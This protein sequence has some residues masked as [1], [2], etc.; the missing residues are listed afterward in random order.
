MSVEWNVYVNGTYVGTVMASR[1]EDA[2]CA[3]WSEFHPS[4]DA[5]VSV[6]KR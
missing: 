1:E 4:A 2:R 5:S 6:S 3:A